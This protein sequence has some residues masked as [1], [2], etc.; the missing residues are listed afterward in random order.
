MHYVCIYEAH[1]GL[2]PSLYSIVLKLVLVVQLFI[3]PSS[4]CNLII[5]HIQYTHSTLNNKQRHKSSNIHSFTLQ[6]PKKICSFQNTHT[7]T[8]MLC[9]FPLIAFL[10]F[11]FS[12]CLSFQPLSIVDVVFLLFVN[13]SA[14]E[15]IYMVC[16]SL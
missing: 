14:F 16:F 12:L 7:H 8:Y 2:Q 11:L 4:W 6:P 15:Y 3:V 5:T 13:R 10:L 1:Y 9:R